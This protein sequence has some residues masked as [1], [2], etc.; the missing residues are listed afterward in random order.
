M[1]LVLLYLIKPLSIN[2][3]LPPT[4]TI[5]LTCCTANGTPEVKKER[6]M[7]QANTRTEGRLDDRV[8]QACEMCVFSSCVFVIE[9]PKV[10]G[11]NV[12]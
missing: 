6:S 3:H 5:V 1:V 7:L 11:K 8:L 10:H 4:L 9:A 2:P 12:S